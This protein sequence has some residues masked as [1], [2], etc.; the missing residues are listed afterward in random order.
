MTDRLV[1]LYAGAP[2]DEVHA[3]PAYREINEQY[4]RDRAFESARE[5]VHT[6]RVWIDK[7]LGGASS[8]R[9]EV[10]LAL[11]LLRHPKLRSNEDVCAICHA[12]VLRSYGLQW[13]E[14]QREYFS[15]WSAFATAAQDYF[16]SFTN[17]NPFRPAQNPINRDH[18]HFIRTT[19]G[20]TGFVDSELPVQ[21]LLA[22]CV[23][24]LLRE[25]K[26]LG[27]YY[28]DHA[29]NNKVVA[30]QLKGECARAFA[31]V[32]LI[33]S[34]MFEYD[35]NGNWCHFEYES[36]LEGEVETIFVQIEDDLSA[37]EIDDLHFPQWIADWKKRGVVQLPATRAYV[38]DVVEAN[39][40]RIRKNLVESIRAA[41]D[42]R[43]YLRIPA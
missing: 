8:H 38:A 43:L 25:K 36:A 7:Q 22:R 41:V 39:F 16:L 28:P 12:L 9:Q 34:A 37:D 6:L 18:Y 30:D 14:P 11:R 40:V 10:E 26:L 2:P 4:A 1:D 33:Q 19:L 35:E 23:R 42:R 21:N 13:T 27:F 20:P 17:R 3:S 5:K 15:R 24:N 31:F 29:E 32:Q